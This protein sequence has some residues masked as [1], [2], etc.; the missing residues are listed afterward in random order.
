MAAS[1]LSV[2]FCAAW[3][4]IFS[5]SSGSS[6]GSLEIFWSSR[7]TPILSFL[8]IESDIYSHFS[9]RRFGGA[10]VLVT[11]E[12]ERM[13]TLKLSSRTIHVLRVP[14]VQKWYESTLSIIIDYS[15]GCLSFRWPQL[16]ARRSMQG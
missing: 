9:L 11:F 1:L 8:L 6:M 2:S 10:T 15:Y 13:L 3:M 12:R 16:A 4:R 7:S 5:S 14:N